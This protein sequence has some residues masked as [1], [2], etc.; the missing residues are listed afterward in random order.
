MSD[1][2]ESAVLD[3]FRWWKVKDLAN[4]TERLTPL[5]LAA[6][7]NGYLRSGPPVEPLSI[8]ILEN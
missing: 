7:V 6:I 8:E 5:S 3:E 1:H 2:V 4:T